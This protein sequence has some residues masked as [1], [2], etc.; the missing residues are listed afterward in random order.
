[1]LLRS[2]ISETLLNSGVRLVI[3]APNADESYFRQEFDHPLISLEKMPTIAGSWENRLSNWRQYLL[4][5]PAL[6][7][8]LN[9]KRESLRRDH[10]WKHFAIRA[11]N[12]VL[13]NI[14]V[15]RKAFMAGEAKLFP[16]REFDEVLKR[17]QPDLVVTGT[18]GFNLNDVHAL[19]SAQ[20]LG[21]QTA[22]V[23]LSWDNLTSK[24]YMNGV[25]DHLLVWSSLMADE[26]V[27]YHDFPR[28]RI[29]ETGAP[30][31]D[32]YHQA[33]TSFSQTQWRRDHN[34]P[35]DAFL[36]VYGTINPAICT[37]E[38]EIVRTI[39]RQ[40]ESGRYT[41]PTYLWIR[42]HP[43]MVKGSTSR[44]I[45]PFLALRSE[46]VHVEIP[47]VQSESLN[48]DLPKS[49]GE[50]LLR[51]LATANLV[52]T[53][54]S[55]LSIDAAC[56]E[57]PIANAFFDG[58]QPVDSTISAGRFQHY[59]HY[60]KILKTGGIAIART[61]EEFAAHVNRYINDPVADAAGRAAIIQQ[62]LGCLDG[63]AGEHTAQKILELAG[64]KPGLAERS[65]QAAR[66]E[67]RSNFEP[68]RL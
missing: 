59:T 25:P 61:P 31:F 45:E 63:Q 13:G 42:L 57:T 33:K 64:G 48:W 12:L 56:V 16:A 22:T 24:G 37:H 44:P 47:P 53:T 18:P 39:I 27:A 65:N 9:Y 66:P 14:P 11:A 7:S 29:H 8:T 43:Q 10:P 1:M 21:I 40:M 26:A 62:Q 32:L 68:T 54:S 51:L 60:A 50:H 41:K 15:L 6:G 4:M 35:D 2:N 23:M 20:R 17:H 46:S 38:V 36:M 3:C 49:D 58:S 5:N 67:S 19:R 30:Q 55:T 28:E 52:V 34:I